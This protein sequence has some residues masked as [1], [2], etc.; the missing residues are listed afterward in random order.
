MRLPNFGFEAGIVP[1]AGVPRARGLPAAVQRSSVAPSGSGKPSCVQSTGNRRR[2][3][4]RQKRRQGASQRCQP[5]SVAGSGAAGNGV[6]NG[7][8]LSQPDGG[9]QIAN[10]GF[11][12]GLAN[13]A[14]RAL[15]AWSM[16]APG[17]R[18]TWNERSAGGC[19]AFPSSLPPGRA[20]NRVYSP[21]EAEPFPPSRVLGE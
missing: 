17:R 2:R 9:F 4:N 12:P 6:R 19:Q 11:Q 10:G 14:L 7:R 1:P 8:R 15:W 5:D 16:A 3:R 13:R 20:R 18:P 21:L